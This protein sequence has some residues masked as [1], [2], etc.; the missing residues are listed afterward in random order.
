MSGAAAGVLGRR[1]VAGSAA[2]AAGEWVP[3]SAGTTKRGGG[4]R[5]GV[6]G[7]AG[8]CGRGRSGWD[9]AEWG[10]LGDVIEVAVVVQHG[11][12]ESDGGRRNQ[13]VDG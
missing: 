1:I 11:Q 13:G 8:A 2:R 3:A 5:A 4:T 10:V 9:R 7:V 12:I 6:G